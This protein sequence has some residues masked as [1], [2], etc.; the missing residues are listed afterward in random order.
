MGDFV[1][2]WRDRLRS[3]WDF[4]SKAQIAEEI[5][6]DSKLLKEEIEF[7]EIYADPVFENEDFVIR[8]KARLERYKNKVWALSAKSDEEFKVRVS[9]LQWVYR[10]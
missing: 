3:R 8:S 10:E 9:S 6:R 5:A 2:Q 4:Y 7:L 1:E